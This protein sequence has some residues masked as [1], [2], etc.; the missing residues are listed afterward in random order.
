[1]VGSGE[2]MMKWLEIELLW[3]AIWRREYR[4][5][6]ELEEWIDLGGEA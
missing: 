3:V 1:M 2:P 5:E 6:R 4:E